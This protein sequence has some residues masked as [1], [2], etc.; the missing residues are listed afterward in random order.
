MPDAVVLVLFTLM[1]RT[2][3]IAPLG[4]AENVMD[5]P[6]IMTTT[7]SPPVPTYRARAA[8]AKLLLSDGVTAKASSAGPVMP[9]FVFA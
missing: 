6:L 5:A 8:T 2:G 7:T 9:L 3:M 1:H 4:T